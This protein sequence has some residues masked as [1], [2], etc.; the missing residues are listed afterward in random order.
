MSHRAE[1][2]TRSSE[3][4]PLHQVAAGLATQ[5]VG[6]FILYRTW[7]GST[8]DLARRAAEAG[9]PE[10]TLVLADAQGAGRG[11]L[12][13]PWVS[14][15]GRNLYLSLVLRPPTSCLKALALLAPLAVS[16]AVEEVTG[17]RPR[18]KWP[19]DILLGP[20]KLSGVLIDVGLQGR[21]VRYA[22]VGIGLNVNLDP[23]AYPQIAALATSLRAELGG[24]VSRV[25]VLAALLNELEGLYLGAQ[26]GEPVW[27][28][29][30]ERLET[31]GRW[32]R[33]RVGSTVE[34]GLAEDV[35]ED[36]SLLLRRADGSSLAIAAGEVTLA[37]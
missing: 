2:F 22:L 26:R 12:G 34:E 36:G 25:E 14:P 10:G 3:E 5:F 13:R 9:A 19:N 17:L 31:V 8:Q 28:W 29:W 30:R 23:S 15:P 7:I 32:V 27:R 4:L 16:R 33:V 20:R 1:A 11:R 6:R 35:A 24:D 18:I 37:P 21:T